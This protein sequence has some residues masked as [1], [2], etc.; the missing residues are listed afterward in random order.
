MKEKIDMKSISGQVFKSAGFSLLESIVYLVSIVI[1]AQLSIYLFSVIYLRTK[2]QSRKVIKYMEIMRGC[3]FIQKDLKKIPISGDIWKKISQDCLI[4]SD[5][6]RDYGWYFKKSRLFRCV[7]SYNRFK[8]K[9]DSRHSNLV[10]DKIKSIYFIPLYNK[11]REIIG[12]KISIYLEDLRQ[13]L[14][15]YVAFRIGKEI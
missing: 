8:N 6:N 12:L 4:W 2:S 14:T 13:V 11:I 15:L 10:M 9:W 5:K 1:L 3:S 7:G